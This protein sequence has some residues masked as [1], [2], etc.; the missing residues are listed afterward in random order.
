MKITRDNYEIWF[1]DY[2]EGRLDEMKSEELRLF[3]VSQ[4]DLAEELEAFSPALSADSNIVY[5]DKELLKKEQYNDPVFFET[6]T[7]A[8]MEGDLNE[9]EFHSLEKWLMNN[10]AQQKFFGELK[11]TKLKPDLQITFQ[12]KNML[13]KKIALSTIWMRMAAVA[14]LFLLAF[15]LFYPEKTGKVPEVQ[16][17]AAVILQHPANPDE[18]NTTDSKMLRSVTSNVKFVSVPTSAIYRQKRIKPTVSAQTSQ[19]SRQ[20]DSINLLLAK[21]SPVY[22]ELPVF[23]DLIPVKSPWAV[24]LANAEIPLTDFLNNK[25]QS[26]KGEG[27]KGFFSREEVI[28]AG[29]HFFSRLPGNH[30][31]GRKGTDGRLTSISLNTQLLAISVPLNR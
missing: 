17:E 4:P 27:P 23:A 26:V 12:A 30:L 15:F 13:K 1:L 14:A 3:L 16:K 22:S 19:E 29:L 2:L 24:M 28:L 7:V 31:T 20:P 18:K 21:T 10:P 6:V 9:A 25:L 11:S 8:A 5:P